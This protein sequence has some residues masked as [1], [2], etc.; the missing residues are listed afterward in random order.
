MP[1]FRISHFFAF[2]LASLLVTIFMFMKP[3]PFGSKWKVDTQREV[4]NNIQMEQIRRKAIIKSV[5]RQK[6][7]QKSENI[8]R[9]KLQRIF[10]EDN[11]HLLYCEVPK[12]GCSNWRRLLI[13]LGG[14]VKVP[15]DS[16]TGI[17]SRQALRSLS[18][19]S[20]DEIRVR[21]QNYTK[22]LFVREPFTRLVS[23]YRD[24]MERPNPFYHKTL[25]RMILREFRPN[26]DKSLLATGDNVTFSEFAQ[27]VIQHNNFKETHWFPV[28]N[29]CYPCDINYDFIGKIEH[30]SVEAPWFLESVG[31]PLSYSRHK[32]TNDPRTDVALTKHFLQQL[33]HEQRKALYKFY[34][35]D[36]EIFNYSRPEL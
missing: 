1:H 15:P 35:R 16:L 4:A 2:V 22:F 9:N 21:L 29:I 11:F 12:V 20:E 6:N 7:S 5:C 36:Y 23:C 13:V 19:Y 27:F 32:A 14:H 26:A 31:V 33:S 30:I 25:G 17:H 10:V 34:R 24:K 28:E 8:N 3:G 18:S